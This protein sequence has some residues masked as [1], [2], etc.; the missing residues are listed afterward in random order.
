[1]TEQADTPDRVAT[2]LRPSRDQVR[3]LQWQIREVASVAPAAGADPV[4]QGAAS[5]QAENWHL[6]RCPDAAPERI[7]VGGLALR[8]RGGVRAVPVPCLQ[9]QPRAR[10]RTARGGAAMGLP[11][12]LFVGWRRPLARARECRLAGRSQ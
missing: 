3:A 5:G 4:W 6:P 9:G 12:S 8:A 1:M 7:L 11:E 2:R 10:R